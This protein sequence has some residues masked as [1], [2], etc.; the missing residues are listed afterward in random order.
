MSSED[1]DTY[2][3]DPSAFRRESDDQGGSG[4]GSATADDAGGPGPGGD[5]GEGLGTRGRV[6]VAA[7][8]LSFFVIPGIVLVRPPGLPFE[9][10]LLVFPLA[11]AVLLGAVAVWAMADRS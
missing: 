7:V 11:P 9:V 2:V 10:A 1:D 8:L 5:A 4:E 3:H 6:L